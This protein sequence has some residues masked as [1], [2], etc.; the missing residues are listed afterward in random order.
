[1]VAPPPLSDDAPPA[2][3]GEGEAAESTP[4]F[5]Q[6]LGTLVRSY[7]TAEQAKARF[8][9]YTKGSPKTRFY[10]CDLPHNVPWSPV[11]VGFCNVPWRTMRRRH[12][13][14]KCQQ[15]LRTGFTTRTCLSRA[16]RQRL[17]KENSSKKRSL[18]LDAERLG[19]GGGEPSP[20]SSKEC[21]TIMP[22]M[23]NATAEAVSCESP[24]SS[25]SNEGPPP[26]PPLPPPISPP[27]P[28]QSQQPELQQRP[29]I[30]PP[31]LQPLQVPL[32]PTGLPTPVHNPF[33]LIAQ[34][35]H[36]A[37]TL[38]DLSGFDETDAGSDRAWLD[39]LLNLSA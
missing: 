30:P 11:P 37:N 19:K 10:R 38:S 39:I 36:V 9:P 28:L 23:G 32:P 33:G 8:P 20:S 2:R 34:D 1:M 16:E 21:Q 22:P 24:N 12:F 29:L 6:N 3:S 7:M 17:L 26:L 15:T 13:N 4:S 27:P 25:F 31:L 5:Y 18:A 35:H 14:G